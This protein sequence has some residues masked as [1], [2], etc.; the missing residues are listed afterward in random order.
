MTQ[1]HDTD[2]SGWVDS[3]REELLDLVARVNGCLYQGDRLDA[4]IDTV[5]ALR[6]D[7]TLARRLLAPA[8]KVVDKEGDIWVL[9]EDGWCCQSPCEHDGV[10]VVHACDEHDHFELD[11]PQIK[12][13]A[14][15]K[16]VWT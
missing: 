15:F 6:D 12:D 5:K 1:I 4:L 14:P 13:L 9:R 10:K 11:H 2:G 3:I 16:A 7:P 8:T